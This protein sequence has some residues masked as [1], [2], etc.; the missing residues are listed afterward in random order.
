MTTGRGSKTGNA[1][2]Q[3]LVPGG[4]FADCPKHVFA[5]IAVSALTCGGDHLDEARELVV[6]EWWLLYHNGIVPQKPPYPD[7]TEQGS[8]DVLHDAHADAALDAEMRQRCE[9][10]E[11]DED[12]DSTCEGRWM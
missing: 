3:T 6:R 10:T 11:R 1:Y 9:E 5:A 7:P 2:S 12:Y 4:M 8:I